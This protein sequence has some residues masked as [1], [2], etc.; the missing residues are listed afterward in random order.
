MKTCTK[1]GIEKPKSGFNKNK[2]AKDGLAYWCKLCSKEYNKTPKGKESKRKYRVTPKSKEII[3]R[4]QNSPKGKEASRN[5]RLKYYFGITL[6][7][8]K[9]MLES[10][11]GCCAICGTNKPGSNGGSYGFHVDH[12][13]GTQIIRGLLCSKCNT[14][15]GFLNHDINILIRAIKYLRPKDGGGNGS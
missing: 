14:G 5:K 13:K 9:T 6:E 2:S 15:L 11:G 1:C 4:Y 7:Q 8:Y 12:I 10:Q 3:R